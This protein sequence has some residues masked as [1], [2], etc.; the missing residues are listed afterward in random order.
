MKDTELNQP[1]SESHSSSGHLQSDGLANS[2]TVGEANWQQ[3]K[4][5]M[6]QVTM[7]GKS[8]T[9]P[10]WT[11]TTDI[12]GQS[13]E[14]RRKRGRPPKRKKLLIEANDD[15]D[16]TGPDA[17]E[18]KECID[19]VPCTATMAPLPEC[20]ANHN[21]DD[22]PNSV[23]GP[24]ISDP[25]RNEMSDPHSVS[26]CK[27]EDGIPVLP[28]RKRGRPRKT[29]MTVSKEKIAVAGAVD[30]H[31][32][33]D[34]GPAR[35][36]RSRGEQHPLTP[37]GKICSD[38]KVDLKQNQL[39]PT[40]HV[41][42]QNKS[43]CQGIKRGRPKLADRQIP[44]KVS[45]LAVS[46]EASSMLSSDTGCGERVETDKQAKLNTDKQEAD[47]DEK[48]R[49]L[50]PQSGVG[51]QQ[52][53]KLMEGALPRRRLRSKVAVGPTSQVIPSQSQHSLNLVSPRG[54]VEPKK[55][56]S[57]NINGS[58][59]FKSQGSVDSPPNTE[60]GSSDVRTSRRH[61][62][63]PKPVGI[64]SNVKAED[65][66][67]ELDQ[68]NSISDSNS[69]T[70]L[71]YN[72]NTTV[73]SE[74][75]NSRRN[76]FG[77]RRRK[78]RRRNVLLQR[79]HLAVANQGHEGD[80]EAQ[81]RTDCGDPDKEGNSNGSS[82][83]RRGK[84]LLKCKDCGR[85]FKFLSQYIIHQRIH[86][87]ER[88][89]K[90][91]ECG[92]GFTKNSNL[93][94][95]LKTHKKS[96]AYQKCPHCKIKFSCAE[97]SA[98][99]KMHSHELNQGS[100]KA[101]S[102]RH[103]R[104]D[105]HDINEALHTV[106]RDGGKQV[107]Q[108]CG[109]TFPFRSALIRHVRVHTG[110]KPYKCD[111]CG[112]AFGQAY[113]LRVHELT[114]WSV[115][116]YNCTLCGKSFTHYSNAKN[117]SCRFFKDSEEIQ[118]KRRVKPSLS[119]TC[120]ICKNTFFQLQ[121][122]NSHMKAHTGAKLYRCLL[123]DKLFGVIS[124]FNAHRSH[125]HRAR[126]EHD[127]PTSVIKDEETVAA[128]QYSVPQNTQRGSSGHKSFPPV[129]T[130]NCETPTKSSHTSFQ[131]SQ[132]HRKKRIINSKK[133]FQS[134]IIP[135]QNLSH[136]VS[137]LNKLDNRSDP[138]KYL[139][140]SC[141]RLFR[142]MGRL[143]AHMLTHARGKSYTC[144]CCGK[145]LENWKKLWH[146]QRIHR[147]RRGRFTCPQCGQGFRFVEPYKRHMTEHPEFQWI[148]GKPKKVSLPYQCEQCST[149]FKTLDLLFNHQLCH[150]SI[151]DVHRD[152]DYDLSLDDHSP[153]SNKRMFSP[154]INNHITMYHPE[155]QQNDFC[156]SS[157]LQMDNPLEGPLLKYPDPVPPEPPLIQV[158]PF[159][160]HQSP[161]SCKTVQRP[162]ST[163]LYQDKETSHD[164]IGENV[165][166]KQIATL[167]AAK[168][169]VTRDAVKSNECEGS[170]EGIKCAVCGN[171]YSI[172][173]DL[174]QHYLQH[175]RGQ[176]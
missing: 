126:G 73:K 1:T 173:S 127:D 145:T 53:T 66:E 31:A 99:M 36:L 35:R 172:I 164:R 105:D 108:Y 122:F 52:S 82:T 157:S 111:I 22:V 114:H 106:K 65:I 38:V 6:S 98:H 91:P 116:R 15:Q 87:G 50:C 92:K 33:K 63:P 54:S 48:D 167:K 20:L 4:Q 81:K 61:G 139:C 19:P 58:E 110:E 26:D 175:A 131:S 136:L 21:N 142:H 149:S 141:G 144:G 83:K 43:N 134:T 55:E 95:H 93:N 79:E 77:Y 88:P 176:L 109:K 115:K 27:P 166:G 140:P 68:F 23:D 17:V 107:C 18:Q 56:H 118:T 76:T 161:D 12:P 123:C 2:E 9:T 165:I 159:A 80:T 117:H 59:E 133:P 67:I 24:L 156:P 13:V 89:F 8:E 41:P 147:Q 154:L 51:P 119:Y 100:E 146:H 174:Y 85:T 78:R 16:P 3:S 86:T 84:T 151:Q 34:S 153:H 102:E 7:E 169:N 113:F 11:S 25:P 72:A 137:K 44:A 62:L 138:R 120:H 94:L 143:R 69:H 28:K 162:K 97:Y 155:P 5:I 37:D 168:R 71:Q 57:M 75:P 103:S 112:K 47:V 152:T 96:N 121:E 45:R 171:T 74:C 128:I 125:C 129:T 30:A 64:P 160:Q 10:L 90:C 29:A 130:M 39:T 163:H 40:V 42:S 14:V 132:T 135:S 32:D 148:Q 124:E 49:H 158:V 101:T 60:P 104:G 70:S 170:S 46:Q 150:S